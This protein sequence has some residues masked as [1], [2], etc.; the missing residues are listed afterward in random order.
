[1]F[2][3][4]SFVKSLHESPHLSQMII[5]KFLY[6]SNFFGKKLLFFL[7][8]DTFFGKSYLLWEKLLTLGKFTYFGKSNFFLDGK[9]YL[10]YKKYFLG[11][12]VTLSSKSWWI[13]PLKDLL[14]FKKEEL[15]VIDKPSYCWFRLILILLLH[16]AH[17]HNITPNIIRGL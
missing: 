14:I 11:G 2:L 6:V 1:M 13:Y 12:K 4:Y 3:S 9:S 10:F 7:K 15:W 5:A 8:K 16:T 17:P